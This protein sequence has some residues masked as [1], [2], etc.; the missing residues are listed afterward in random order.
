MLTGGQRHVVQRLVALSTAVTCVLRHHMRLLISKQSPEQ[1]VI[2]AAVG[3][4]SPTPGCALFSLLPAM[5]GSQYASQ[6]RSTKGD[7][8]AAKMCFDEGEERAACA[9]AVAATRPPLHLPG[10]SSSRARAELQLH[11]ARRSNGHLRN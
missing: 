6:E 7:F 9:P 10:G 4:T 8:G 1:V 11:V 5:R 2:G 3:I